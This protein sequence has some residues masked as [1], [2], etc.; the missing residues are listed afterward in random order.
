MIKFSKN[1]VAYYTVYLKKIEMERK[2]W[3]E[4]RKTL[5]Y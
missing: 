1:K 3:K 4:L 2:K 5:A